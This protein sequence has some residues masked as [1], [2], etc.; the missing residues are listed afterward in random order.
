M[1]NTTYLEGLSG[2]DAAE[3]SLEQL[4]GQEYDFNM[5]IKAFLI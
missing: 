4:A 1:D 2:L 5:L 3:D